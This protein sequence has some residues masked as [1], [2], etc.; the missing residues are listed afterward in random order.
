MGETEG[1][2]VGS[3]HSQLRGKV[4]DPL[5]RSQLGLGCSWVADCS[6]SRHEAL[7]AWFK[8]KRSK[9]NLTGESVWHKLHP[10]ARSA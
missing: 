4:K 7:T 9:L 3:Q 1:R 2:E 6:A 10:G 8:K 5:R